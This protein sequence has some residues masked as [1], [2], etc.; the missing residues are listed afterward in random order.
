MLMPTTTPSNRD[1]S[2][3]GHLA[4]M[5]KETLGHHRAVAASEAFLG[6]A[7]RIAGP[8]QSAMSRTP[9]TLLGVTKTTSS[10][11]TPFRSPYASAWSC[12]M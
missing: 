1:Q 11:G 7:L 8:G 5:G 12:P 10:P 3:R 9:M 6:K 4:G 2:R